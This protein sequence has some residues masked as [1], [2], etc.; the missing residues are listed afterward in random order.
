[1]KKKGVHPFFPLFYITLFLGINRVAPLDVFLLLVCIFISLLYVQKTIAGSKFLIREKGIVS[2][3]Y[4]RPFL[5][6]RGDLL[7]SDE[8][9]RTEK[10]FLSSIYES[11]APS[12]SKIVLFLGTFFC[13]FLL[14]KCSDFHFSFAMIAVVVSVLLVVPITCFS[15]YLV[16][17]FLNGLAV[18]LAFF[19]TSTH[20][21]FVPYVISFFLC[22]FAYGTI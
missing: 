1:M 18:L 5:Y 11:Q 10:R 20:F 22:L 9:L 21:S 4:L 12:K 2:E 7:P 14:S 3:K 16:P 13:F 8:K 6:Y 19:D 17:L 15:H